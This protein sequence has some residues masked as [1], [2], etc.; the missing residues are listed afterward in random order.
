V[1]KKACNN[2]Q[3]KLK[4]MKRFFTVLL[5]SSLANAGLNAQL[6][7]TK[8]NFEPA[9][10]D[11]QFT[12]RYDSIIPL[13]RS[14]GTNKVWN[15]SA[16]VPKNF[17]IYTRT[18]VPLASVPASSL[19]P[20]ATIAANIAINQYEFYK[21]AISPTT[22][23]EFLGNSFPGRVDYLTDTRIDDTWPIVYGS[24][25]NDTYLGTITGPV[26]EQISGTV[27][28]A[29]TGSGTL[30]L[31][32]GQLDNVLQVTTTHYSVQ[33]NTSTVSNPPSLN[34]TVVTYSYY[35]ISSK[36]PVVIVEDVKSNLGTVA[37]D[38]AN[39]YYNRPLTLSIMEN[40]SEFA[41]AMYPNPTA[42]NFNINFDNTKNEICTVQVY[43]AAGKMVSGKNLGNASEI[44]E[45]VPVPD[46]P[47][48]IYLVKIQAGSKTA[49][50]KLAVE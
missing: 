33:T 30:L 27:T 40:R 45:N 48:G 15:C 16:L 1:D 17:P 39:V 21:S 24:S 36:F 25:T 20:G 43:D 11:V 50:K 29:A 23:L 32:G 26:T 14:Q 18:F 41:F 38:H 5:L 2:S 28:A 35:D 6:A 34:F 13:P 31:P 44:K 12:K 49:Y 22:Q 8:A 9:E 4:T 47:P 46:L 19:F 37:P 10:G 42:K 7:L 3:T